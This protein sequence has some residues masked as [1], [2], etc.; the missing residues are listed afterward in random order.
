MKREHSAGFLMYVTRVIDGHPVR[1]YLLLQYH[2]G[3][4]DLPKGKLEQG[5]T[6]LDAALREV[7][8]ETGLTVEPI[9]GFVSELSYLFT[10][11]TGELIDKTVT[12]FVGYAQS[13]KVILSHEHQD[14]SWVPYKEAL[15]KLTYKNSQKILTSAEQFLQKREQ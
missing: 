7:K 15:K 9:E 8:E 6:S 14:Y 13:D 2:K 12:F 3:Y 4:W 5:E 1:F 11:P 10:S